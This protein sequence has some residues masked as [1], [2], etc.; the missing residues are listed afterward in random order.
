MQNNNKY[1]NTISFP[2]SSE[3]QHCQ[4]NKIN[5]RSYVGSN[6][7][8]NRTFTSLGRLNS[9]DNR[10]INFLDIKP[11]VRYNNA[12]VD[13]VEILA[14]NRNKLGVYRWINNEN[15]KTYVGSS[16]NLTRR[17]TNYYSIGYLLRESKSNNSVIYRALLKYGYANFSLEILE[18]CETPCVIF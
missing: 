10:K 1:N 3:L 13:K 2:L 5:R 11:I 6:T 16:V 17:F 8:V 9:E 7:D 4:Q 15:G 18:Y 12:D 14:D